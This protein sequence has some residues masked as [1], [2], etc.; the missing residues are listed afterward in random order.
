MLRDVLKTI[1]RS[2]LVIDFEGV[3]SIE[4]CDSMGAEIRGR[5]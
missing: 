3:A 5:E 4:Q 2:I 1:A